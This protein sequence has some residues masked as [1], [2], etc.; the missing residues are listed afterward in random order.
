M[1]FNLNVLLFFLILL[2]VKTDEQITYS[3]TDGI[4]EGDEGY[5]KLV[6]GQSTTKWF[7]RFDGNEYLYIIFK[8][9]RSLYIDGYILTSANDVWIYPSRNPK[10]WTLMAKK[11]DNSEWFPID[12]QKNS[13]VLNNEDNFREYKFELNESGP[14]QYFKFIVSEVID[15]NEF[16]LAELK[17]IGSLYIPTTNIETTII[18]P[19]TPMMITLFRIFLI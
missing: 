14:Y 3:A 10:S 15:G 5:D 6:D 8:A 17:L 18:N 4:C 1:N 2:Y 11:N 9:S 16:Q 19:V 12:E 7:C 13:D